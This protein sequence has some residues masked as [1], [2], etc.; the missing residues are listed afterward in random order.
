VAA[1]KQFDHRRIAKSQRRVRRDFPVAWPKA[2]VM[3]YSPSLADKL[4]CSTADVSIDA[5]ADEIAD[6]VRPSDQGDVA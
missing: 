4:A 3:G 2:D 5:L 1:G 6:V